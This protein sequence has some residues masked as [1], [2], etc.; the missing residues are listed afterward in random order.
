MRIVQTNFMKYAGLW[1]RKSR[2]SFIIGHMRKTVLISRD[3]APDPDTARAVVSELLGLL[4]DTGADEIVLAGG[5][6]R[7]ADDA[8][9]VRYLRSLTGEVFFASW[10]FERAGRALV[11]KFLA[12][13]VRVVVVDLKRVPAG[14]FVLALGPAGGVK[15]TV[16]REFADGASDRWYPLIDDAAC[17]GCMKCVD[18]C[19]F[20]VYEKTAAA[21]PTVVA[22]DACK[23][24]CPACARV[25]PAGA[26]IFPLYTG[27]AGIAGDDFAPQVEVAG[28][29][30]ER[31]AAGKN[32]ALVRSE[33]DSLIDALDKKIGSSPN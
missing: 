21:R 26:I 11:R 12:P 29:E 27:H 28:R 13:D 24:G 1:F 20:G 19:L 10:F 16:V 32:E 7:A 4:S 15:K 31:C 2:Q 25:C 30:R 9:I 6:Y 14:E 3:G 5:L 22:P 33:L 23:P 18:F 17:T 8:E